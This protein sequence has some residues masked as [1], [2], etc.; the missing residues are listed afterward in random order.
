MCCLEYYCLRPAEE[1]DVE[2]IAEIER[3]TFSEEGIGTERLQSIFLQQTSLV[4]VLE[5]EDQVRGYII[6]QLPTK[7]ELAVQQLAVHPDFQKQGIG[8][9]LLAS[10]KETAVEQGLRKISLS[11]LESQISYF[12]MNGFKDKEYPSSAN[13]RSGGFYMEWDNPYYQENKIRLRLAKLED[14][15]QIHAIET[16]NFSAEEA[17]SREILANHIKEI[18]TSF[19]VAE[20]EGTILGYLEGPVV[21][22][23][24]LDDSSFEVVQDYSNQDG[25][26]I[27]ITSLSIAPEA[28]ARG[29]GKLLLTEMKSIAIRDFR[30][31]I[32]LTCHDYLIPYYERHGFVNEG[33]SASTYA[34]E[35]WYNM[36]WEVP[37]NN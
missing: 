11:C 6:G 3:V 25:G 22:G 9:L 2:Q 34:N 28:Q 18:K 16:A 35:I 24:Y 17:I 14:L 31:G 32:N 29:I 30:E 1:I 13:I 33:L 37:K 20:E 8:T 21:Q 19:L 36:V 5:I 12:E 10:V 23:R 7:E 27:S 26:F 4:H 15:D